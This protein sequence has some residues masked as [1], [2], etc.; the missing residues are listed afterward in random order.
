MV[1][2]CTDLGC[3]VDEPGRDHALGVVIVV[4]EGWGDSQTGEPDRETG[5]GGGRKNAEH[6]NGETVGIILEL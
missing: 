5:G 6:G 4:H 2:G 1:A 3:P